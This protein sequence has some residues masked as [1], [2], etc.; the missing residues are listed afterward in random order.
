MNIWIVPGTTSK[1]TSMSMFVS[2][3]IQTLA[4]RDNVIDTIIEKTMRLHH[5]LLYIILCKK[6]L[7]ETKRS[8]LYY[9]DHI[10]IS[11]RRLIVAVV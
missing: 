8:G 3:A 11:A 2:P 7:L 1:S 9:G 4:Y 5:Q 10:I 6:L